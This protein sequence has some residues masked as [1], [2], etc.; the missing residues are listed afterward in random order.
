MNSK[1]PISH[2][3]AGLI[4]GGFMVVY[5]LVLHFANLTEQ[6]SAQWISFIIMIGGLIYF[7]NR[8]GSVNNNTVSFGGL[9]GYGFK[10][11]TIII[12]FVTLYTVLF[13]T[14]FPEV[15]EQMFEIARRQMEDQNK[16]SD[17]EIDKGIEMVK[18]FFWVFT[19][20]GV[21]LS[22]AIIGAAGSLIGAAITKRKPY[23]PLDQLDVR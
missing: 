8:H 9:F 22:Y 21:L 5:S 15:R 12:L 23:N 14:I 20:G 17:E 11:T 1:K 7:V 16:L 18:K 4:L 10:I 19:I 3:V 6:R 13:F 2:I